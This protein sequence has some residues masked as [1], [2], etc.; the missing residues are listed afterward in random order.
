MDISVTFKIEIPYLGTNYFS[1]V[2][3]NCGHLNSHTVGGEVWA[4][5]HFSPQQDQK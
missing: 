5:Q 2:I 4:F 3:S 1:V